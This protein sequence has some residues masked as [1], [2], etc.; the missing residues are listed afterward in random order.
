MPWRDDLGQQCVDDGQ[1]AAGN[2]AAG[3][4]G[5]HYEFVNG[6]E[7]TVVEANIRTANGADTTID[8]QLE[9]QG[10]VDLTTTDFFI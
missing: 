3:H 2:E 4:I 9:L 1:H 10:H 6:V 5:F 7:Y 8:F